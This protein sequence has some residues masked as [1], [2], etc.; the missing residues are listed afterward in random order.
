MAEICGQ[1]SLNQLKA[2]WQSDST[3]HG[4]CSSLYALCKMLSCYKPHPPAP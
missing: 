1:V 2:T 3:W 4:L